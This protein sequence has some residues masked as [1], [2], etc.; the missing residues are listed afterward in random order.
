MAFLQETYNRNSFIRFLS[1]EFLPEDFQEGIKE[2]ELSRNQNFT[3]KAYRLGKC[4]SLELEVFEI[5]HS[6]VSD[7][8]VGIAKDAFQMLLRHSYCNR[9][10]VAFVPSEGGQWRFSLLQM[11]A[12][13]S[14][15]NRIQRSYSNPRRYSFLLGE[16]AHTKTPTQFLV[17]K[18]RVRQRTEGNKTLTP[19]QDLQHRFSIEA[20]TQD[21]YGKLYNWYLWAVDK[22]SEVFFPKHLDSAQDKFE[23]KQIKVIRLITRMLFVWFIKQKHLVPD[24]LFDNDYLKIVLKDF[25]PTSKENGNYYNAILQ[26]LFF[27]TLNQETEG[28]MLFTTAKGLSSYYGNKQLYRDTDISYFTFPLEER[29][30]RIVELFKDIPYLNGGLFECLDQYE[31]EEQEDGSEKLKQITN[32]D[33]FSHQ[34][35]KRTNIPNVLFFAQEHSETVTTKEATENTAEETQII[36][37]MGLLELF[38][39]Y[40]FTVEENTTSDKEVSLDPELLGRVFENLLAAYNPETQESARKSTGSFYTPREIVEYMVEESL[41]AYLSG[42]RGN[43]ESTVRQLVK[44]DR[45]P[46]IDNSEKIIGDLKRIK[47]LDPACGSGAFPMGILL[48]ITDIIEKLTPKEQFNRYD[49]KLEIIKNCI[50]GIDIQA[51]AMLICKLR[52]FI[53]LICDCE[54]DASKPNF[55]IIPLPNLETKFVAANSLLPAK[56]KHYDEDWTQDAHLKQLQKELLDLRVGIFDKRTHKAKLNNKIADRKKCKEIAD[57]IK[58]NATQPDEQKIATLQAQIAQYESELPKYAE[59]YWVDDSV[60]QQTLFGERTIFRRNPNKEKRDKLNALI[61]NC[62]DEIRKEQSKSAIPGFEQ[63]VEEVTQWNPYNQNSVSPFFDAEWMFGIG[64]NSPTKQGGFDVVIGNPP[65]IKEYTNRSAFDGFRESSPYYMGKMDLWYGFAC[66]GM[67]WLA[68]NG[69]LCFIAQNNWT[70]SAGAK[71]MR[72]KIVADA[73]ILKLLDFN[74]YMVFESADIQT[75]IMLFENSRTN[76]NYTFDYRALEAGVEKEDMFA[77]LNKQIR[78]TIYRTQKFSRTKFTNKLFTFSDNELIFDKISENK[79]YLQD[80]EVAQG[81]VFPQDFLDKKGAV[82]LEN[83]FPVGSGIFGLS[84]EEMNHLNLSDN[85]KSII[86]PYFSTEQ[87]GRYYTTPSNSRWLIYTD[88]SFK[89]AN[90]MDNY[91]HIKAHLDQFIDI[92]TSDNKPYGLHRCR[93]EKFFQGE[94]IISLRKC[95][96]QPCFSYSDFDCYVTQTFFSI[97]T[98]R[99]NM[100]FLT[101]VLNSKLI[102]FWLRHKGKMQGSNYQV[103]KEPLQGIPLPLVDLSFQQPI[104][105][106]VDTI[107]SKKKQNAQADTTAEESKIDKEVYQLYRLTDDEVKLIEQAN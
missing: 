72:D 106:L 67:D 89:K 88:S 56:V 69:V 63:A 62:K 35:R 25:E 31:A 20:L 54:K 38:K 80:D 11:E 77:L 45:V 95:V 19:I 2:I 98:S 97:K 29:K 61:K 44:D 43:D 17:E 94:K 24:N 58:Q 23:N 37:V 10:L 103:D 93:K 14:P 46:Q 102:A 73:K 85:E 15:T 3:T 101:G 16:G 74:T 13:L 105:D 5:H 42:E 55:G 21:F 22:R 96:G 32:Y 87:I 51:I 8:R 75:M 34:P 4:E 18:G 104:I 66:H 50:Y 68:P 49:T 33:G 70:T 53:S 6:S 47:I 28:R 79:T 36:N 99:W 52:F 7:A 91:P 57:Y 100:K 9:A 39:Q 78:R 41:I 1:N 27:A 12:E 81:I 86:K 26:N 90:S 107:L 82:K 60:V 92:F 83:R 59:D 64:F 30:Q 48:K 71:K 65:Y 84:Y 76:D 40:N